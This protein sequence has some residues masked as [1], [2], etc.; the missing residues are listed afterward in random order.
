MPLVV[1]FDCGVPA[2]RYGPAAEVG[3]CAVA[4]TAVSCLRVKKTLTKILDVLILRIDEWIWF[5]RIGP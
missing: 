3:A 2:G 5:H 1:V 4:V